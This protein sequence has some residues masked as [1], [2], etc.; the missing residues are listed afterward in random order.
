MTWVQVLVRHYPHDYASI[1]YPSYAYRVLHMFYIVC[2]K[3][4]HIIFDI[5]IIIRPNIMHSI[6]RKKQQHRYQQHRHAVNVFFIETMSRPSPRPN[7]V[8][9]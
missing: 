8:G 5:I 4:M 6:E 3:P 7:N 2:R 1:H 9:N